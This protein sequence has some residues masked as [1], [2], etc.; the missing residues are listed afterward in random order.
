MQTVLNSLPRGVFPLAKKP[1][2]VRVEF[3]KNRQ[4]RSRRANFTRQFHQDGMVESTLPS[5]ET[6]RAKGELSRRRTI[7]VQTDDSKSASEFS[8]PVEPGWQAGRVLHVSGNLAI[9]E[10]QDGRSC[11]CAISRVLRTIAIEERSVV[12]AGDRVHFRLAEAAASGANIGEPQG[13]IERV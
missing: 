5:R 8:L 11:A 4:T 9:V 3:R 2:K 13:M 6:V 1:R 12:T 10:A 7:L